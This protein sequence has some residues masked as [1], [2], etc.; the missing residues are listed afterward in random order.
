MVLFLNHHV[1]RNQFW[2]VKEM[3]VDNE[4]S[5]LVHARC[6]TCGRLFLPSLSLALVIVTNLYLRLDMVA[7][8]FLLICVTVLKQ[9]VLQIIEG[10]L[11]ETENK[12]DSW[13][14]GNSTYEFGFSNCHVNLVSVSGRCCRWFC[15]LLNRETEISSSQDVQRRLRTS[16]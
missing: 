2:Y 14:Y 4:F 12:M 15:V 10:K 11:S 1:L 16:R 3:H 13:C 6:V 7:I 9:S 5:K 8:L